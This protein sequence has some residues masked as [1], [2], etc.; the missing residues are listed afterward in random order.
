MK[1]DL[2]SRTSRLSLIPIAE[3]PNTNQNHLTRIL[4]YYPGPLMSHAR[5]ILPAL[6]SNIIPSLYMYCLETSQMDNLTA[7]RL[8][9]AKIIFGTRS[10]TRYGIFVASVWRLS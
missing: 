9:F 4:D 7:L 1:D 3:R 2:Y 10:G 6:L 8:D 5:H